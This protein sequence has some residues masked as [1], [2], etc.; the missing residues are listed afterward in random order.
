MTQFLTKTFWEMGEGGRK[1]LNVKNANCRE[2]RNE[3]Y[4][5][6]FHTFF[7]NY[8]LTKLKPAQLNN[9]QFHEKYLKS[10]N[11]VTH[12]VEILELF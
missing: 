9:V 11:A 8:N 1:C 10:K 7:D 12:H 5:F 6:H 3:W 4:H 2:M